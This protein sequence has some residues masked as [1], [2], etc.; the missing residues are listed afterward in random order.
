MQAVCL[1]RGPKVCSMAPTSGR[2]LSGPV[3][4]PFAGVPKLLHP[5]EAKSPL[6]HL[7]D[8]G[9]E[10]EGERG[11]ALSKATSQLE[12]ELSCWQLFCFMQKSYILYN[13]LIILLYHNLLFNTYLLLNAGHHIKRK[14]KFAP[15]LTQGNM[16][17]ESQFL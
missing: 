1:G 11:S 10:N 4:L 9:G 14:C 12:A 8:G 2:P 6:M 3:D 7:T 15:Y 13:R 17:G 5:A 16:S